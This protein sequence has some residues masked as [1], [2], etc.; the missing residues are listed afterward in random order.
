VVVEFRVSGTC[1]L[2]GGKIFVRQQAFAPDFDVTRDVRLAVNFQSAVFMGR[3]AS[4]ESIAREIQP[5]SIAWR[6][7]P[8]AALPQFSRR[9]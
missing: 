5:V 6:L 2:L 4:T 8:A 9:R 7:Q 1:G 3:N